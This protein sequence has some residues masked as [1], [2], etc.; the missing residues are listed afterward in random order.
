MLR[1]QV[2]SKDNISTLYQSIIKNN[3]YNYDN[4]QKKMIANKI[5]T[6]LKNVS[7]KVDE[8]RVNQANI[9]KILTQINDI[10]LKKIK[11][12]IS[13]SRI[14]SIPNDSGPQISQISMQRDFMANPNSGVKLYDR[15][16]STASSFKHRATMNNVGARRQS[17]APDREFTSNSQK[18]SNLLE[19]RLARIQADRDT[20]SSR[21]MP[22]RELPNELKPVS[23]NPNVRN[24]NLFNDDKNIVNNNSNRRRIKESQDNYHL[25][26][27]TGENNIN[28][29][30]NM[31]GSLDSAFSN[32]IIDI[33]N[34]KEDTRSLEDRLNDLKSMRDVEIPNNGKLPEPLET[35]ID[36]NNPN[37]QPQQNFQ[38]PQQNYQQ[39]QQNYQQ[40]QPNY[41]QPQQNFQQ[42]QQNYQQPQP[43][44][45][46]PQQNF[47]Q[48]PQP[49]RI[50][51]NINMEKLLILESKLDKLNKFADN[52]SQ[53]QKFQLIVDSRK[54][55]N[56]SSNYRY[57]LSR[58]VNNVSKIELVNYSIPSSYYNITSYNN[59]FIYYLPKEE[60]LKGEDEE[61]VEEDKIEFEKK[62]FKLEYGKYN[63]EQLLQE[64]N[65][66]TE[67]VF[68]IGFN[69]KIKISY[70]K[71]FKLHP[72]Q[73]TKENLGILPEEDNISNEFTA[74]NIFDLR[75]PSYF[76]LYV[77]NIDSTNPLAILNIGSNSFG[78]IELSSPVSLDHLSIRIVDENNKLVDFQGRYHSLTFVLETNN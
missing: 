10:T 38:Q 49:N 3:N 52:M 34:Y 56:N 17:S 20:M 78:K 74:K 70:D 14:K 71:P 66:K 21:R 45:Q 19:D 53:K 37:Q 46:Q 75:E 64:L 48:I 24:N 76:L 11:Q 13:F 36:G 63:I 47:Q 30:G 9:N 8:R 28:K 50:E 2:L 60:S 5:I 6:G 22:Q 7:S 12:E 54:M 1:K 40:P 55:R 67:L 25:T 29:L 4:S 59:E 61:V 77:D 62:F 31:P 23:T 72:T 39:P 58:E 42:P 33:E 26:N 32:E 43:N 35:R 18:D 15:P 57:N 68:S 16:E 27:D 44:Y 65:D 69:Q 51:S 41:Q 73:F